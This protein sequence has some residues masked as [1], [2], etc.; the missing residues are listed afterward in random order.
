MENTSQKTFVEASVLIALATLA[1]IGGRFLFPNGDVRYILYGIHS[2]MLDQTIWMWESP[3]LNYYFGTLGALLNNP[4]LAITLTGIGVNILASLT[5][6]KLG[7]NFKSGRVATLSAAACT[8]LWFKPMVGGWLGDHIGFLIGT[9]PILV[10][11]LNRGRLPWWTFGLTGFCIAAGLTLKLNN[12]GPGLALSCLWLLFLW[13]R[14]QRVSNKNIPT[15]I[16]ALAYLLGGFV[17]TAYILQI[18]IPIEG[19]LYQWILNFYSGVLRSDASSQFSLSKISQLPLQLDLIRAVQERQLGVLIF[20]PLV[21]GFWTALAFNVTQLGSNRK[22]IVLKHSCALFL[23]VSSAIIGYGLARGVTHR[24]FLIPAGL[25]FSLPNGQAKA[26]QSTAAALTLAYMSTAFALFAHV[27]Y[28]A[29]GFRENLTAQLNT[30]QY[31]CIGDATP[32][33]ESLNNARQ[34]T[35]LRAEKISDE[36]DANK[37]HSNQCFSSS[38]IREHFA[39]ISEVWALGNMFNTSFRNTAYPGGGEL[40]EKWSYEQTTP[41]GQEELLEKNINLI[42]TGN[43]QYLVERIPLIKAEEEQADYKGYK[44]SRL[45]FQA[46]LVKSLEAKKVGTLDAI[47][48][49]QLPASQD[50]SATPIQSI[51]SQELQKTGRQ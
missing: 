9:A 37:E 14:L 47:T 17:L 31:L 13:W 20:I 45:K 8:A 23:L 28:S 38:D 6:W 4:E 26:I 42:K 11:Y 21:I 12:T 19:G 5:I 44:E 51:G 39:G 22:E 46:Q 1:E 40:K 49:W 25:I 30:D 24:I 34:I 35:I 3:G 16:N 7:N 27:Q 41:Q 15:F 33:P 29:E 10:I 18:A 43:Y 36:I 32:D 48:I 50:R 2:W